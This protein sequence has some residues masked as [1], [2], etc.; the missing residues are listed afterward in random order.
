MLMCRA[1]HTIFRGKLSSKTPRKWGGF[2]RN[3]ADHRD[4]TAIGTAAGTSITRLPLVFPHFNPVAFKAAM[5]SNC[6]GRGSGQLLSNPAFW[7]LK[8][9]VEAPALAVG[10]ATAFAAPIGGLLFTVEEGASFYSTSIFW[11]GFLS[12]GIGVFTLHFLVE[13]AQHPGNILAAHFG[14]YRSSS[15]PLSLPPNATSQHVVPNLGNRAD[16]I[17]TFFSIFSQRLLHLYEN[18][19]NSSCLLTDMHEH[20]IWHSNIKFQIPNVLC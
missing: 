3:D 14:R 13:L 15:P 7:R 10:V 11:R 8:Y 19:L 20:M 2:F 12:T 4:F 17:P 1:L 6:S 9:G 18:D 16:K 5:P